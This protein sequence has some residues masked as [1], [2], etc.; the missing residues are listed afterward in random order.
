MS[1]DAVANSTCLIAL[2]RIGRLELLR[3][4]FAKTYAPPSV[5]A[6]VGVPLPWV[7]ERPSADSTASAV[8]R[9]Q[10]GQGEADAIALAMGMPGVTVILDDKKA[11]RLA[12]Q[13]G[14]RVVGTLGVIV[15][16]KRSGAIDAVQPVI[17]SLQAAGF[18]VTPALVEE[19]L[20][21]AGEQ[22]A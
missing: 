1:G 11:R 18:F 22:K 19:A 20:R 12:K 16:A 4:V 2:E 14:L 8:L 15:R 13:L 9:T 21:L 6:E 5:L 7:Q 3:G 10:L 17:R